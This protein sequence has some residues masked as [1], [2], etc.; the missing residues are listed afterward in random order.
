MHNDEAVNAIKFSSLAEKGEYKYDPHEYHGPTLHYLTL[1]WTRLSSGPGAAVSGEAS[2]RSTTVLFGI[3]LIL[4]TVLLRSG[5]GQTAC[6]WSALFLAVSP[7]FVFYSRYFIHEILL[8]FFSALALG[9][10]WRYWQ[11]RGVAWALLCGVSLGMMQA[12]KETF[13]FSLVA[14]VFALAVNI[15]WSHWLDASEPP[16][17]SPRLNLNHIALAV[18]VWALVALAFFSSFFTNSQGPLDSLRTY[19]PWLNRAGGA[20]PHVQPWYFYLQRLLCFKAAAGPWWSESAIGAL[21]LLGGVAGFARK[22]LSD[23]CASLVRFLAIYTL[24]LTAI[25][26]VIPYKTPWC[27]LGF[28]HGAILLAGVGMAVLLKFARSRA[29]RIG[30]VALGAV[31]ASLLAWQAYQAAYRFAADRRN[32][33]VYAHTSP[34]LLRLTSQV[35]SLASASALGTNTLIKVVGWEGDYWPLPYYLRQFSHVGWWESLPADPYAPIMILSAK[36]GAHLD[37]TKT[38]LMT[39]YFE[40]RPGVFLELYVELELW[41]TWLTTHPPKPEPE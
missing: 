21:A 9:S 12:T 19:L 25:Y 1:A 13:V 31:A 32:P 33:Y 24:G 41:K 23:A 17:R 26:T 29:A 18:G 20:S 36:F 6:V 4:V 30:I 22:G 38:H 11:K 2:L 3:G 40:L 35:Q 27:L 34:D 37:E 14:A 28:W 10:G 7:A 39:G 16:A 5:L 8:V 15:A